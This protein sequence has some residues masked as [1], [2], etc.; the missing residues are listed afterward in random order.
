MFHSQ[1]TNIEVSVFTNLYFQICI[2]LDAVDENMFQFI[3]FHMNSCKGLQYELVIVG[4]QS[5]C[6]CCIAFS[7]LLYPCYDLWNG[8]ALTWCH[9]MGIVQKEIFIPLHTLRLK[10]DGLRGASWTMSSKQRSDFGWRLMQYDPE[11]SDLTDEGSRWHC[12]ETT[13][14][15]IPSSLCLVLNCLKTLL[16]IFLAL[17]R[18]TTLS[19]QQCIC[20]LITV[21]QEE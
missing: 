10:N 14:K 20:L 7:F 11:F 18:H 2:T 3:C 5:R 17:P 1:Y 16:D 12:T 4:L 19:R 13:L 6:N 15:V 21:A 8:L 9:R